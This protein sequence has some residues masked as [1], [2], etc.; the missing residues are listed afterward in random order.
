RKNDI[1]KERL[2]V[3]N[4]VL[5]ASHI[6]AVGTADKPVRTAL[7]APVEHRGT[8]SPHG[9]TADRLKIF[10]DA[11]VASGKDDDSTAQRTSGC[12]ETSI[13]Q[14]L[15]VV[16]RQHPGRGVLRQRVLRRLVQ[17]GGWFVRRGKHEAPFTSI[18]HTLI[19]SDR[20]KS[21]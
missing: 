2:D 6:T 21:K 7:P 15:A 19:G 20:R 3:L 9:E 10:L 8:E 14:P 16:H 12:P 13:A 11:L 18:V 1:L 4:I 17:K 5:E